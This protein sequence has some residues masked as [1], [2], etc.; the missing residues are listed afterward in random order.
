[1]GAVLTQ[2]HELIEAVVSWV[3]IYDML[4]TELSPNG[5]FNIPESG[6]VQDPAQFE[7]LYAYSPYHNVREGF[8]YPATLLITGAN[9]P[10]VEPMQ[11]RKMTARLQAA[12]AGDALILLRTDPNTGHGAGTQLDDAIEE[13]TDAFAFILEHIN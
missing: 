11:S 9:D 6:T 7:A 3:G 1:M 8:A 12:Q 13:L 2:D 5:E 4:R 10:R